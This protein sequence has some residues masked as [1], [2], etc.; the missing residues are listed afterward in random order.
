MTT[1]FPLF[2]KYSIKDAATIPQP[3]IQE[4]YISCLQLEVLEVKVQSETEQNGLSQ[5]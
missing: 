2:A 3:Y 4:D 1:T 5:L